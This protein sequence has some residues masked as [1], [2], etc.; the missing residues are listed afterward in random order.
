M[1][2]Q[3]GESGRLLRKALMGNALFS[4]LSGLTILFAQGSVLRILGLS[5]DVSLA[6]L[7]LG[8]LVFAVTLVISARRQQV[9]TSDAW[10]AVL[11]DLAWVLG[12]YV[13]IF[14]V[15]FSTE[16]KWVVG[17]VAEL[18]LAFAVLQFAGIRRIQ[19]SERLG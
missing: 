11:M 6:I 1:N 19:K 2:L 9:K 13:L 17:V 12:S 4:T 3:S 7:G 18:V 10:G 16:G 15:P 5:K 8:L 14:V